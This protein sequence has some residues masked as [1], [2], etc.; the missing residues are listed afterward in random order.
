MNK[1]EKKCIKSEENIIKK[2]FQFRKK[3]EVAYSCV[4]IK[5][6]DKNVDKLK[7]KTE[8]KDYVKQNE[9]K[10][11]IQKN[12]QNAEKKIQKNMISN[13]TKIKREN[14]FKL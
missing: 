3:Q 1:T 6:I 4:L 13:R 11:N 14:R 7:K 8:I 2:R 12:S 5:K 9:Y 10:N